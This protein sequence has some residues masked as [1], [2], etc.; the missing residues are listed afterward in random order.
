MSG[1]QNLYEKGAL[2]LERVSGIVKKYNEL[3]WKKG[4][5]YNIFKIARIRENERVVCRVIADL[6]NPGGSHYKGGLYLEIFLNLISPLFEGKAGQPPPLDPQKARVFTEY[7]AGSRRIDIVIEDGRVFIPLEVKIRAR[8]QKDQV[9]CYARFSR[10]KNGKDCRVPVLY[11]SPEGRKPKDAKKEDYICLS[12]KEH[13][14]EWLEKCLARRET[15]DAPP[16]REIIKQLVEAVKSLCGYTEDEA[17]TKEISDLILQSEETVKAALAIRSLETLD[18]DKQARNQ[19]RGPVCEAVR[20][21]VPEAKYLEEADG[22]YALYIPFKKG[23]YGLWI[24]YDWQAISIHTEGGTPRDSEEADRLREKM[25]EITGMKDGKYDTG[26][27][28][29]FNETVRYPGLENTEEPFYFYRLYKQ[30]REH[31]GEAGA[32]IT[33]MA[34][35][36]ETA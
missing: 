8:D 32:R 13:I 3:Y 6:L 27:D 1:T 25:T 33:E 19:F 35:M 26:D 20:K 36:L 2:L 22:W 16:V 11:L 12:C 7:P 34:R 5:R 24:N 23:K 31:T 30:Y 28:V 14:L 9:A 17:M 10:L 29:W 18:F 4:L 15:E 21:E